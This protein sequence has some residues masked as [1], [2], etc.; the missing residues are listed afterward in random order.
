MTI[1]RTPRPDRYAIVPMPALEDRRLSWKARGLLAYLLSR[2]DNW[3]TNS[4]SLAKIA[5]DGR[6]AIRTGL[7]ELVDAGYLVRSKAQDT[8]GRWSTI[9]CVYD[10]AQNVD[11]PRTEAGLSDAGKPGAITTTDVPNT[12]VV[13]SPVIPPGARCP[14]CGGRGFTHYDDDVAKCTMCN[15]KGLDPT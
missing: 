2:P 1:I 12:Y 4:S 11:N 15:G 3:Q 9:T 6:D 5:P 14:G 8:A 7:A 10:C 13:Q